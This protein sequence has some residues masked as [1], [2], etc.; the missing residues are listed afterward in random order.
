MIAP[1]RAV[2]VVTGH[3]P[4]P[5]STAMASGSMPNA[6]RPALGSCAMPCASPTRS[7]QRLLSRLPAT[8]L[9]KH[10]ET[11]EAGHDQIDRDDVIEKARHK[12]DEDPRDERQQG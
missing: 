11:D 9:T 12:Q 2:P 5:W 8:N 6:S 4:H 3:A 7:Q 10:A 1:T